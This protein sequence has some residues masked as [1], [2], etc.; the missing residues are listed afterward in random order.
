MK[1]LEKTPFEKELKSKLVLIYFEFSHL[2]L[3]C[4]YLILRQ[5]A[6]KWVSFT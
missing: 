2:P 6:M 4:P 5:W 1:V 3:S